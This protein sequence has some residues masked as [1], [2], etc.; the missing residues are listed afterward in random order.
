[1]PEQGR[2]IKKI[3]G[4]KITLFFLLLAFI[5]LILNL[6]NIYYRK[7]KIN[8]DIN[9]L[10]AQIEKT[11][12]NNQQVSAMLDYLSSQSFLEKQAREKLNMK[13]PGEEVVIIEPPKE[14][15]TTSSEFTAMGGGNG[16]QENPET[17]KQEESN[18]IKWWR[19]FFK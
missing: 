3:L 13:K 2:K 14:A 8:K 7:Y 4:S 16:T 6:V 12:K 17:V 10:K 1:M 11:E 18:F 9:D 5:W 15:A 19:Y